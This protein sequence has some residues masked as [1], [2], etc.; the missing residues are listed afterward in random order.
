MV[1]DLAFLTSVAR[2]VAYTGKAADDSLRELAALRKLLEQWRDAPPE[3]ESRLNNLHLAA[4]IGLEGA[5]DTQDCLARRSANILRTMRQTWVEASDLPEPVRKQVLQVDLV[6]GT[7][8]EE[9]KRFAAPLVGPQLQVAIDAAVDLAKQDI[10]LADQAK[11][12]KPP[13]QPKPLAF[14][15]KPNGSTPKAKKPRVQSPV[16]PP[17]KE[18]REQREGYG[19]QPS[20]SASTSSQPQSR[21]RRPRDRRQKKGGQGQKQSRG[22]RGP[23]RGQP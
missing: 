1:Q 2:P 23:R 3:V 7:P 12:L 15:K 17:A 22:G 10:T 5:M 19:P 8:P 11:L 9:G 21:D 4:T 14:K 13:Q 6:G 16:V 20:T 18:T